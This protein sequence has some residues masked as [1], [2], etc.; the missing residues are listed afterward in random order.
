M[1]NSALQGK[2]YTIP[3]QV[4]QSLQARAGE[5]N[6]RVTALIQHPTQTY[7]QLKKL[8]HDIESGVLQGDWS[9]VILWVNGILARDRNAEQNRK[10]TTME[11]GMENRFRK[12]HDKEYGMNVTPLSV[13][14]TTVKKIKITEAQNELL[15]QELISENEDFSHYKVHALRLKLKEKMERLA[16]LKADIREINALLNKPK[17]STD[18]ELSE[19]KK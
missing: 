15:K 14:E 12:T 10:Q 2:G 1:A 3:M 16:E 17:A 9:T 5:G 13:N 11:I 19:R 18:I 8:K 4:M 7:E 6:E